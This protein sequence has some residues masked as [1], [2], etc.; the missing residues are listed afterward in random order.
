[1][2]RKNAFYIILFF[3]VWLGILVGIVEIARCQELTILSPS[4][5]IRD[6]KQPGLPMDFLVEMNLIEIT[7]FV[8]DK[9]KIEFGYER[10]LGD[11]YVSNDYQLAMFG[12]FLKDYRR[13]DRGLHTQEA[14]YLTERIP[15]IKAGGSVLIDKTNEYF[16]TVI[17]EFNFRGLQARYQKGSKKTIYD[18]GFEFNMPLRKW[19]IFQ[20]YFMISGQYYHDLDFRPARRFKAGAVFR[21]TS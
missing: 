3:I 19:Y 10:E 4:I 20:M 7:D 13:D 1:M 9:L 21:I 12:G 11:Y 17:T 14:G 5:S 18:I 15:Y 2:R 8:V 6:A 16:F